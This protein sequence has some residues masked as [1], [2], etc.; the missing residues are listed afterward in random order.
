MKCFVC[1]EG[2]GRCE[3]SREDIEQHAHYKK[4]H[5]WK[6]KTTLFDSESEMLAW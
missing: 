4:N 6:R 3:E 2:T 5:S 1:P